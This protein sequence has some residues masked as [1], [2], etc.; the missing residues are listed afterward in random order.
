MY[1]QVNLYYRT[2]WQASMLHKP[3]LFQTYRKHNLTQ[4]NLL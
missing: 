3:K 2:P 1:N 4:P